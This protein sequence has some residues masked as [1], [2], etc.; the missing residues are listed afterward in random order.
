MRERTAGE[1]AVAVVAYGG[2]SKP[3]T[4]LRILQYL[5]S[6]EHEGFSFETVFVPQRG[7]TVELSAAAD[8]VDRAEVVFVQR[9][10][11]PDFIRLLQTS[12]KP[13][14][15]DMDDALHYI[16]QS[17][18]PRA[19]DPQTLGDLARNTY[20]QLLRGSRYYSGRK[21][22]LD[23]ML[24]LAAVTIV[25]NDWLYEDLG[26]ESHRALVLPTSVWVDGVPTKQHSDHVPVRL[27]WIGTSSNLYHL[28]A[29]H[30]V[31]SAIWDRLGDAVELNVVSSASIETPLRTVFTPW[32]LEGEEEAVMSFDVGLMP[33]QDDPFSRGKCAFKAVF[34][35]SRGVPVVASPVGANAT[36]VDDGRNGLLA[37]TASE[38]LEAISSLAASQA[39]RA[40]LGLEA[41]ETIEKNYSGE[42]AAPILSKVLRRALA[43]ES[44]PLRRAEWA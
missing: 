5:P 14:V 15:F 8:A 2:E 6:L 43:G 13:V 37:A 1:T 42:R 27:G 31:F 22:L 32:S 28:E 39:R 21:R 24:D 36:V 7:G 41:R 3:S 23:R 16:R 19:R 40:A 26:L 35:M 44:D 25:G 38:W 30:D 34:C 33:L 18:Y 20:R 10:L 11:D 4:R 17:Q 12:G 29:L 9:V